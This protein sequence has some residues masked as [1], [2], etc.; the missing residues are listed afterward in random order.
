[1]TTLC[2]NFFNF[3]W[4]QFQWLQYIL[5]I[6]VSDPSFWKNHVFCSFVLFP[7][8]RERKCATEIPTRPPPPL[9]QRYF[10][11]VVILSLHVFRYVDFQLPFR[12]MNKRFIFPTTK[13]WCMYVIL[14]PAVDNTKE[15][16]V[17]QT[18]NCVFPENGTD[19]FQHSSLS[20]TVG[21]IRK[22]H[23]YTFFSILRLSSDILV[24][25]TLRYQSS[26]PYQLP[27]KH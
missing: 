15:C 10:E 16:G 22:D 2:S 19:S 5:F 26:K 25:I 3:W 13:A 18:A 7:R 12:T 20:L 9:L 8:E 27:L 1:M 14:L 6:L 24:G 11:T 23:D 4:L 17:S 21:Y